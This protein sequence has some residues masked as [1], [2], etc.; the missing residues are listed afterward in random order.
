MTWSYNSH[1]SAY[2]S[3]I[4]NRFCILIQKYTLITGHPCFS[5]ALLRK[6]NFQFNRNYHTIICNHKN[7]YLVS[8]FAGVAAVF[9][10]ACSGTKV[11]KLWWNSL[12]IWT[13]KRNNTATDADTRW[14]RVVCVQ[15]YRQVTVTL[16]SL[17]SLFSS[18]NEH[19]RHSFVEILHELND[20][21]F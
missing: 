1:A 7:L 19:F 15:W 16:L 5:S 13:R 11:R 18:R 2:N 17:V 20:I 21:L 6:C 12:G 9:T 3:V 10:A 8:V 14:F 4:C